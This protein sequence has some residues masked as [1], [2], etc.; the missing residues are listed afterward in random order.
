MLDYDEKINSG[1]LSIINNTYETINKSHVLVVSGEKGLGKKSCIQYFLQNKENVIK[2]TP[3]FDDQF[4]LQPIIQSLNLEIKDNNKDLSYYEEI[5]KSFLAICSKCPSIIYLERFNEYDNYTAK[6]CL[7]IAEILLK[8]FNSSKTFI[9]FEFDNDE[10]SSNMN[11]VYKLSP[12]CSDFLPFERLPNEDLEYYFFTVLGEI[13]ISSSNL[14]YI[15]KSAFGN[16]MYLNIA[17]NYLRGENYIRLEN[18]KLNCV[19]LPKGI[20]TNILKEFILQRYNL[21]DSELKEVLSKS[22]MIGNV[23]S[24]NSLSKPFQIINAE[25]MLQKIE[26]ISKL[27]ESSDNESYIFKNNDVYDLIKNK[28]SPQLQK[29]W[30]SV[31][32]NY[33]ENMLNR[34]KKRKKLTKIK[35]EINFLYPI[36]NHYMY[37][38]EYE[39]AIKYFIELS[40]KYERVSDY[41][42][43]LYAIE[44]IKY[45][46]Q[47]E[48]IDLDD[49][50]YNIQ[51]SEADCYRNLGDY[52]KAT[53]AYDECLDYFFDNKQDE[54]SFEVYYHQAYCMY[55]NGEI[56][57]SLAILERMNSEF[58]TKE[59]RNISYIKL[60]SLMASVYDT[61]GN[62][63][64]QKIYYIKALDFYKKNRHDEDYY[65]L[66]RMSSMIFDEETSV[67]MVKS[68]E[69]FFRE[70]NFT[71]YLAETLHNLATDYLYLNNLIKVEEPINEAIE[72]FDSFG[73]SA[74]HYSLNTKGIFK[75]IHSKDYH[76]AIQIFNEA[77]S[78]KIEVYSEIAIHINIF[79][80]M[81]MLEKFDNALNQLELIDKLIKSQESQP[82]PI[83]QI[84]QNLNWAFYYY[85]TNEYEK[86]LDRILILSKL[87]YME[88]RYIYIY[89]LLR[90]LTKNRLGVKTH[91]TAGIAQKAVYKEC[92]EQGFYFATLR[93]YESI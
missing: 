22:S 88:S 1:K 27:L 23:F 36:A 26:S 10:K 11:A 44:K 46:L 31:L 57:Q 13:N 41:K 52:E 62:K 93:F 47:Y 85:N 59:T 5:K 63:E 87:D 4:Q 20:L 67:H 91:Y 61:T 49:L 15:I 8:R 77:L 73:S 29:E 54:E 92:V 24:A 70:N 48:D 42:H 25:E 16:I 66:I 14:D 58:E 78:N 6:F 65:I 82:V 2:I 56:G 38:H 28:V 39:F 90:Y 21:L 7:E 19:D 3:N 33:Y 79:N 9:I 60:I 37:A 34:E 89:K 43:E 45:L 35:E 86:C 72:L 75:M 17:I 83:Y 81:I 30:H 74:V 68:A 18:N 55:M 69:N 76:G 80:C 64:M 71:K 53:K 40:T 84:Y 32:A 51:K 50:E 12:N